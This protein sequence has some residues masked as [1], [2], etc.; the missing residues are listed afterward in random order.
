[1]AFVRDAAQAVSQI[2]AWLQ[3]QLKQTGREE[4][5]LGLSGG[6]DSALAAYLAC[7]AVGRDAL[8]CVLMPY[9][10]SSAHSL[11]D[12]RRVMEQLGVRHRMVRLA[13]PGST[14]QWKPAGQR[15]PQAC[16]GSS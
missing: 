6:L 1:M 4:F 13:R 14:F 5:V 7:E 8:L 11:D 12:A 16:P 2:C 3:A 15:P 9:R 10:T